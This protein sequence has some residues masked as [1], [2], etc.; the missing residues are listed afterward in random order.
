MKQVAKAQHHRG[1]AQKI[2][3]CF[4]IQCEHTG[5]CII[6]LGGKCH[7]VHGCTGQLQT[8]K[9]ILQTV[10]IYCKGAL[11]T[12]L[13]QIHTG[14]QRYRLRL[15][16]RLIVYQPVGNG[17]PIHN[18]P[19]AIAVPRGNIGGKCCSF[20]IT[21]HSDCLGVIYQIII[22]L[23]CT[24]NVQAVYGCQTVQVTK[25]V[26]PAVV[27]RQLLCVLN[28]HL[29]HI[30]MLSGG[31]IEQYAGIVDP[32]V[33]GIAGYQTVDAYK[34]IHIFQCTLTFTSQECALTLHGG[35]HKGN[36]LQ[37]SKG[38]TVFLAEE[39]TKE[40]AVPIHCTYLGAKIK[41][42]I[43]AAVKGAG[44]GYCIGVFI[45][46][47]EINI[48]TQC[49]VAVGIFQHSSGEVFQLPGIADHHIAGENGNVDNDQLFPLLKHCDR[50]LLPF[51]ISHTGSIQSQYA[52]FIGSKSKLLFAQG[53]IFQRR[54]LQICR[55]TAQVYPEL[56]CSHFFGIGDARNVQ[57]PGII[58]QNTQIHSTVMVKYGTHGNVHH[59][60]VFHI[61][62][63]V[64]YIVFHF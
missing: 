42:G 33:T 14:I 1:F 35:I 21:T 48:R 56:L 49:V 10:Q 58:H 60:T 30:D 44:K 16:G 45:S 37:G 52:V 5:L 61:F 7:A 18:C 62:R 31:S 47:G 2:L 38:S 59:C 26:T 40:T 3:D 41:D 19:E 57:M 34:H 20:C 22:S 63:D 29:V 54:A 46:A 50:Q 8:G 11:D 51:G 32:A 17:E 9:R 4:F 53:D 36:V 24:H 43:T 55:L 6:R 25:S 27:I 64:Q 12:A 23:V 13:F 28:D 39:F 15:L